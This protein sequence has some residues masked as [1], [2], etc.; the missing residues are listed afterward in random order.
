[1]GFSNNTIS[2][3]TYH[4]VGPDQPRDELRKLIIEGLTVGRIG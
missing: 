2:Y 1:M 3:V 4:V